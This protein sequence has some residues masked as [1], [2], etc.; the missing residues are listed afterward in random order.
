[1]SEYSYKVHQQAFEDG[2][3]AGKNAWRYNAPDFRTDAVKNEAYVKGW[4]KGCAERKAWDEMNGW[5]E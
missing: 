5:G 1:M 2:Y 4:K 3:Q